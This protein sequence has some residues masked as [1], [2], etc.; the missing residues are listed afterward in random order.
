LLY[1]AADME[2]GINESVEK[3]KTAYECSQKN[4]VPKIEVTEILYPGVLIRFP[5]VEVTVIKGLKGPLTIEPKKSGG[6]LRII[7]SDKNSNTHDLGANASLDDFWSELNRL[8]AP[9]K[10]EPQPVQA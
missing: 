6:T 9:S 7:A 3:I 1:A 8:L 4:A 10:T 2:D 5:M